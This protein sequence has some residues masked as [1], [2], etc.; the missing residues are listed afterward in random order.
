M[1]IRAWPISE[2]LP[3]KTRKSRLTF[4]F[5]ALRFFRSHGVKVQR[6][7]TDNGVS[8]RSRWWAKTLRMLGIKN[9]RTRPYT[10]GSVMNSV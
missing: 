6:V 4:L 8:I 7:M 10:P 9:K 5:N 3:D 1:T 2:I